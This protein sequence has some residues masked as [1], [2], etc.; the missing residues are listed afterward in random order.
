[1]GQG[2]SRLRRSVMFHLHHGGRATRTIGHEYNTVQYGF[3]GDV[4][5][6]DTIKL[7]ESRGVERM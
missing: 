3:D 6:A 1:M 7:S 2:C 5:L 4:P